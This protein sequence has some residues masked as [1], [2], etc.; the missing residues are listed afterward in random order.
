MK[1][2]HDIEKERQH[3]EYERD[4]QEGDVVPELAPLPCLNG[5]PMCADG[6][7]DVHCQE[8]GLTH[9]RRP[10]QEDGDSAH[11]SGGVWHDATN[12]T[13]H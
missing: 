12:L 10:V 6:V 7:H 4:N 1:H 8:H 9:E 5:G 2:T 3:S 11:S 13:L